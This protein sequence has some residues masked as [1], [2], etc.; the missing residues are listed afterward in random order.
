M[1]DIEMASL[2]AEILDVDEVDVD[3]HFFE[4]GGNSLVAIDV[5]TAVAARS[6]IAIPLGEFFAAP[7]PRGVVAVMAGR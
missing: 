1:T 4:I 2:W 6:G 5:I 7:T 3:D